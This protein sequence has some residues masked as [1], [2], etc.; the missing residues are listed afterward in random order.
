MKHLT[1]LLIALCLFGYETTLQAQ[2][3]IPATGGNATGAGGTVSYTI[4]QI[5]Y[6]TIS[7]TT[8][9]ITQGVQQPF[10]ISVVTGIEEAKDII[11]EISVYPN[12]ATGYVKLKVG[13]YDSD[14][15]SYRLYNIDGKPLQGNKI[16]GNETLI[17]L[18]NLVSG[19]Y[20]LKVIDHNKELK[21]FK[22]I[23]N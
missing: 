7:G 13:N 6:T 18:K 3:T 23:K 9:I 21:T 5:V 17:Q 20:L 11:L 1:K 19:T 16:E 4:G 12:P 15:L 22:I 2:N 14:N 10:E 8:G